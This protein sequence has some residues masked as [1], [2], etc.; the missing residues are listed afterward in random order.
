MNGVESS[1]GWTDPE[2]LDGRCQLVRLRRSRVKIL[3]IKERIRDGACGNTKW[4]EYSDSG[5]S[6]NRKGSWGRSFNR[7]R[8]AQLLEPFVSPG[9]RAVDERG[10]WLDDAWDVVTNFLRADNIRDKMN[11][12]R[13]RVVCVVCKL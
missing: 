12:V 11:D 1:R 13:L 10:D 8:Q 6:V 4:L 3:Y 5:K 9:L 2:K 7:R